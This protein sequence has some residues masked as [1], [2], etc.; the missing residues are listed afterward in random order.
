MKSLQCLLD[1][2]LALSLSHTQ[3]FEVCYA[4]FFFFRFCK[5]QSCFKA[6]ITC[7]EIF[8]RWGAIIYFPVVDFASSNFTLK[9]GIT[10]LVNLYFLN[11]CISFL[12]NVLRQFKKELKHVVRCWI[13]EYLTPA[14][15]HP[16][17]PP[18]VHWTFLCFPCMHACFVCQCYIW[19]WLT[20]SG[21]PS[22]FQ[23]SLHP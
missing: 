16:P 13:I 7:F 14:L 20:P 10:C 22:D 15:V 9:R 19:I 21:W 23:L 6:G 4:L 5:H 18:L 2:V 1:H 12:T 11:F 8:L 3:N 17:P